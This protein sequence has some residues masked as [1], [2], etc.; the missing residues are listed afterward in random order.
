MLQGSAAM[1]APNEQNTMATTTIGDIP[2]AFQSACGLLHTVHTCLCEIQADLLLLKET[3]LT[4]EQQ[5]ELRR[6]HK[7]AQALY[8][9]AQALCVAVA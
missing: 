2:T 9:Q 3:G 1:S 8:Q 6:T 5:A 4:P 7:A